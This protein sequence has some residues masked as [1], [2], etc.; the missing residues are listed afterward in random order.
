M[1][2]IIKNLTKTFEVN[3]KVID[4]VSINF[5]KNKVTGLIGFNGS[6]KTTTFNILVDFIEKYEGKVLFD[7]KKINDIETNR[8]SY[9]AAGS[10]P[11]NPIWAINHL[12]YIALIYGLNKRKA[13]TKI[14]DLSNFLDFAEFLNKPIS[15]LSK[16][17][18]QKIKIIASFLN[19]Q[20]EYLF[21][22][23]PFDGLDPLGVKKV[24]SLISDLKDVTVIIT[25]HRMEIVDET[26]EEFFVLKEG[27]IIDSRIIDSKNVVIEV[28]KAVDVKQFDKL[29]GVIETIYSNQYNLIVI[30][31]ISDFKT[32]NAKIMKNKNYV[33]STIKNKDLVSSVFE[34]YIN[35]ESNNE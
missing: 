17:N 4:N 9:L 7:G 10:E 5:K 2:I 33:Y 21:L 31:K 35:E 18:Q 3:K 32:I 23:E 19:P 13:K 30:K 14:E 15:S 24:I 29:K 27:K 1:S 11:K 25:S 34:A 26:C 20:M 8:I 28:N 22:D 6:G 16:G 12:Y